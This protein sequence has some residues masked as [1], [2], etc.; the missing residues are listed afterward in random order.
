MPFLMILPFS[1]REVLSPWMLE[2]TS[3]DVGLSQT[4]MGVGPHGGGRISSRSVTLPSITPKETTLRNQSDGF[5]RLLLV[6]QAKA[7]R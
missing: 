5:L 1:R 4:R 7:K 2:R 3:I 6:D